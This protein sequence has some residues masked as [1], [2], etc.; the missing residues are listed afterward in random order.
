MDDEPLER[1]V[2]RREEQ[3]ERKRGR[4]R[5]NTLVSGPQRGSHVNPGAPRLVSQWDGYAWQP[6]SVVSDLAG[7]QAVLYGPER[8]ERHPVQ[9]QSSGRLVRGAGT[10]MSPAAAA[11][12]R[13]KARLRELLESGRLHSNG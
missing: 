2:Q 8:Q 4:L 13:R 9:W 10:R 12:D 5:L 3:R 1:W 6:V 11:A 7:A